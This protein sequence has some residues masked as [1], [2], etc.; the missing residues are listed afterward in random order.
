MEHRPAKEIISLVSLSFS[1]SLLTLS[2]HDKEA[3][4]AITDCVRGRKG[5]QGKPL[6][7]IAPWCHNQGGEAMGPL[8][9]TVKGIVYVYTPPRLLAHHAPYGTI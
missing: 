9:N 6:V 8:Q 3:R 7:F 2:S 5:A 4:K 1:L